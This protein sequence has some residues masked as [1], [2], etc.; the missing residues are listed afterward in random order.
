MKL[1]NKINQE[2]DK[3]KIAIKKMRIKLDTKIK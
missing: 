2:D 3:K 1:K